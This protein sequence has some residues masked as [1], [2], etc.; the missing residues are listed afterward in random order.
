MKLN[1][2][3]G[4]RLENLAKLSALIEAERDDSNLA[5]SQSSNA[6]EKEELDKQ[7]TK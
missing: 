4:W 7:A 3:G 1:I 6:N 5:F 2:Y